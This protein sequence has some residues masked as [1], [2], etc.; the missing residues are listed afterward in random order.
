MNKIPLKANLIYSKHLDDLDSYV[1]K[2]Y[3]HLT[4]HFHIFCKIRRK[5]MPIHR[6]QKKNKAQ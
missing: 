3:H 5:I 2:K 6:I 4:Q 1:Y